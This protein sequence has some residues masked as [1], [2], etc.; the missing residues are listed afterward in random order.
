M[1]TVRTHQIGFIDDAR[2]VN[3]AL[4]RAKRHLFIFGK[5]DLLSYNKVWGTVVKSCGKGEYF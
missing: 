5:R 2:R 1:S 4:T 3:V